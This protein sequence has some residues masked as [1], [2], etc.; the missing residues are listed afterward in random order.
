MVNPVAGGF[1]TGAL[2]ARNSGPQ[3]I[4]AGAVGFA[5]FSGA[6]DLYMRRQPSDEDD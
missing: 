6:I 3:G 1:I 2:L 4:M 5:A